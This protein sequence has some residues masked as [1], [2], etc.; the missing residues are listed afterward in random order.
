MC[1]KYQAPI[2]HTGRENTRL[3]VKYIQILNV[4][5]NRSRG[6]YRSLCVRWIVMRYKSLVLCYRCSVVCNGGLTLRY[7][8]LGLCYRGLVLC[9]RGIVRVQT[10]PKSSGRNQELAETRIPIFRFLGKLF[11]EFLVAVSVIG[12]KIFILLLNPRSSGLL[13]GGPKNFLAKPV[14][15]L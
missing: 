14:S 7:R 13:P 3:N 6:F 11:L 15:F 1:S 9:T 2:A 8:S 4:V 10:K 5:L 12:F